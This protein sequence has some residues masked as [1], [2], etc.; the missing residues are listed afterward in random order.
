MLPT[1]TEHIASVPEHN[2]NLKEC[3]RFVKRENENAFK[4]PP[5]GL[6]KSEIFYFFTGWR[7]MA[8]PIY[9]R[10]KIVS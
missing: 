6:K 5:G 7:K 9:R 8:G 3:K 10:Q 1:V 2:Y 4:M